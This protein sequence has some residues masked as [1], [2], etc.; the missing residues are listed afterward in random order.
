MCRDCGGQLSEW[1]FDEQS[2]PSPLGAP[3]Q[4]DDL[5]DMQLPI[6]SH[7]LVGILVVS[8]SILVVS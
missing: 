2:D 6:L 8:S 4:Q 1:K 3:K 5:G 7:S